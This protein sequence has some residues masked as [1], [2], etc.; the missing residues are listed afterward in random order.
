[1]KF[2]NKQALAFAVV[3]ALAS[4]NA[5]AAANISTAN[6]VYAKEI[7][8]PAVA[9]TSTTTSCA[10]RASSWSARPRWLLPS[11]RPSATPPTAR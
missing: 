4:G 3:G 9:T 11:P 10:T 2:F 8:M 6:T 5:L 7:A 1:M